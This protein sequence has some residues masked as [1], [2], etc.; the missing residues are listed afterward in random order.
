MRNKDQV[1]L[2]I[3]HMLATLSTCRRRAVGCVLI[4]SRYRII[5]SGY[6]GT[7]AGLDHCIDNPCRHADNEHGTTCDSSHAEANAL[8][9]CQNPDAIWTV[10]TTSFPCFE[11]FKLLANT[12][13][14]RIVYS[15]NYPASRKL[16]EELNAQRSI[17][18]I[19][20]DTD[21]ASI[22]SVLSARSI[23]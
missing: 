3:A 9:Q 21:M 10:Y 5:G 4:D 13:C 23:R 2:A 1:F 11:C 7:P 14:K 15:K 18:F 12:G 19:Y 22:A 16:V 8:V 17:E 6:N 20:R